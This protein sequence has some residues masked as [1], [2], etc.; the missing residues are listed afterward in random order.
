MPFADDVNPSE[1]SRLTSNLLL[2]DVFAKPERF[3]FN[4]LSES[5]I[6]QLHADMAGKFADEL[7]LHSPLDFF[8]SQASATVE[9]KAPTCYAG[10]SAAHRARGYSRMLLPTWG[11]GRVQL[12]IGVID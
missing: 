5:L 11:D 4:S 9:A 12:L 6:G 3:R 10:G 7:E 2:V 1:L 8:F